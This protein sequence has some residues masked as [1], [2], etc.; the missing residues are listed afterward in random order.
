MKEEE[1]GEGCWRRR[2]FL[3]KSI[4]CIYRTPLAV[5][6]RTRI[7]RYSRLII[8]QLFD[9]HPPTKTNNSP[10]PLPRINL[11]NLS[12]NHPNNKPHLQRTY[13]SVHHDRSS[14]STPSRFV[15]NTQTLV[16]DVIKMQ[17]GCLVHL[18]EF[19]KRRVE[20]AEQ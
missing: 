11:S 12:S 19:E 7:P 10:Q 14:T 2:V 9:H 16:E 6:K 1:N 17:T 5:Q 20:L 15:A 3:W 13:T 18:S 8:A 4:L